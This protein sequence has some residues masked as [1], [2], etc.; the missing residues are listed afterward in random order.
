MAVFVIKIGNK[1]FENKNYKWIFIILTTLLPQVTFIGSYIN[2]D[3][4]ALLSIAIIV[5]S[6]IYGLESKWNV[7]SC[8]LLAIGIGLCALSYYNAYGYILVSAIIFMVYYIIN[9]TTFKDFI[10]KAVLISLIAFLIAGWWFIR[11]GI[12]YDGDFLGLNIT[13]EYAE[14]YAVEELKP[15]NRETPANTGASLINMLIQKG[16]LKEVALSFIA[17]FGGMEIRMHLYVYFLYLL[18]FAIGIIGY[19][20]K[21]YK[22]KYIKNMSSNKKILEIIFIISIL[23]PIVLS[24]Y[25]SY[26]S[27][28][29][30]Q[31]RYLMP[32]LIPFIYFVT[33]GLESILEKLIKNAKAKKIVQCVIMVIPILLSIDCIITDIQF[34]INK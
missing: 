7:K 28:Y 26:Y 5:Y 3:S 1:L 13:D 16:W 24:L 32:I 31:G 25:Y 9:K 2:N 6:W 15:S 34:Y 11:S 20:T 10:K 21:F 23:I 17:V 30:P 4:L 14:K 22:L 29:Q 19:I 27:D 12:I 8:I 18:I 33:V